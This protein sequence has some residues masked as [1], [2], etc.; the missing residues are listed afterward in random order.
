VYRETS[1]ELSYHTLLKITARPDESAS[2]FKRRCYQEVG[3]KRDVE[4]RKLEKSYQTKIDRLE[5]RIRR[6]E[7]ELEQDE[8]E[9]EARKR[10]ELISAG[11]SVLNMLR[12]RRQSRMLSTAS[13]KRRLTVQ[14]KTE[15]DESLEAIEDL[16]NQIG[17]LLDDLERERAEIQSRWVEAADDLETV[18]VR[19]R[20]TDIYVEE[21]GVV[22]VPFWDVVIDERGMMQQLSL[23]AFETG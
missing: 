19:P 17:V 7:R 6:E 4:V 21:W 3:E 15:I 14:S 20:K 22:W 2:Q 11:E 18:L 10:E 8:A 13:R 5:T 12:K 23:P 16:E 1:L 9:Y